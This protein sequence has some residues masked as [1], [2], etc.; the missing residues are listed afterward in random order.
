MNRPQK[1][2]FRPPKGKRAPR[3]IKVN[4]MLAVLADVVGLEHLHYGLWDGE[5]LD[6]EGLERAQER[7]LE[8]LEA[9]IP[10]GVKRILDV[11]CGTGAFSRRLTESGFEVEGLSPDPKQQK[12]YQERVGKPFH[13]GA[14]QDF[15]PAEPFD[16][17]MMSES[18]QYVWLDSLFPAIRR[19]APGGHVL[20]A[21]YFVIVEDGSVMAKS[22]HPLESFRA[23]AE[24]AGLTLDHEED[25]TD[26]TLPTLVLGRRWIESYVRSSGGVVEEW[27]GSR[28]PWLL[29]LVRRMFGGTAKRKLG[30]LEALLDPEEFARVKRYL[31][32]RYR[33]PA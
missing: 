3:R 11:G 2:E 18:A 22:G 25:I 9:L 13:L 10:D 30:E 29:K 14:F 6:R 15:H 8:H 17:V 19:A 1:S 26:A 28:R 32:K 33:V 4:L 27:I 7:Y 21:D 5:S 23:K 16:L 12:L 20:L 31:I 24:A